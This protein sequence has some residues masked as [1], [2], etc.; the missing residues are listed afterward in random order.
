MSQ[1]ITTMKGADSS[2]FHKMKL[3]VLN[4]ANGAS[5]TS[6]AIDWASYGLGTVLLYDWVA[7]D[8]HTAN[9]AGHFANLS[10][11]TVTYTWTAT[12]IANALVWAIGY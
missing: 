10:G 6:V 1:T 12:D 8:T 7:R 9:A 4:I 2:G 5:E 3:V 11:T